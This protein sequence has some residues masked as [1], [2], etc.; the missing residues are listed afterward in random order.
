MELQTLL[1]IPDPPHG[2]CLIGL[3]CAAKWF[4]GLSANDQFLLVDYLIQENSVPA[5]LKLGNLIYLAMLARESANKAF[6]PLLDK[7]SEH[8]KSLEYQCIE[9]RKKIVE[10]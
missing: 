7:F 6:V 5:S 1:D 8:A 4:N 10:G 9:A 3:S 2:L